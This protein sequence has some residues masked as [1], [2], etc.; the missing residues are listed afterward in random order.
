MI[1]FASRGFPRRPLP[2]LHTSRNRQHLKFSVETLARLR[3][4]VLNSFPSQPNRNRVPKAHR[5]PRTWHLQRS[6]ERRQLLHL[7]PLLPDMKHTPPRLNFPPNCLAHSHRRL[8]TAKRPR[9]RPLSWLEERL[10]LF[11][12]P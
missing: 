4:P 8:P 12:K 1:S 9:T 5:H 11:P 6:A 3:H 10:H 2:P 7:A